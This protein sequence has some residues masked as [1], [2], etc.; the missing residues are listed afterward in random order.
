MQAAVTTV[1][2]DDFRLTAWDVFE[3]RR[4]LPGFKP[5]R[6]TA[7]QAAG[8]PHSSRNLWQPQVTALHYFNGLEPISE[9]QYELLYWR[10]A[11]FNIA[12]VS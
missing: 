8:G 4:I 1:L 10:I 7:S 3:D 2:A 5:S 9:N 11:P 12:Q 6:R